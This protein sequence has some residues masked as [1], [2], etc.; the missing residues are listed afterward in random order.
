MAAEPT[1][2]RDVAVLVQAVAGEEGG[3]LGTLG[4]RPLVEAGFTGR[5][6]MFCEPTGLRYLTRATAAATACVEVTGR[7]GVD[8]EPGAADNATVLLG[9]LAQY[10][11]R[12]LDGIE[13][14]G[15]VCVAGLRTGERHNRVYGTGRLLVNLS[16]ADTAAGARVE[17]AVGGAVRAGIAAFTR[18][19]AGSREFG[20]TADAAARITRLRWAKRGLPCL[21]GA[22]EWVDR[23]LAGAGVEPWPAAEPAFTC[24]AIWLDGVPDSGTVILGPGSPAANHAHGP[25]E[26]ADLAELD[27]F[28]CAVAAVVARFAREHRNR[29]TERRV[30]A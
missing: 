23:L 20:R 27:A 12:A 29:S 26:F 15:R 19:F 6:N 24:D 30:S 2:G 7:G 8:D 3:A 14:S 22:P 28:A 25:G 5:L 11:A 10:L 4:T 21:S 16:Y 17:R 1:L 18:E 9:F 13:P